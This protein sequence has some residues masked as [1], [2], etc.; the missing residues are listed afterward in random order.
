MSWKDLG[1]PADPRAGVWALRAAGWA[2]VSY[3]FIVL[4]MV[5]SQ[6][7]FGQLRNMAWSEEAVECFL[8]EGMNGG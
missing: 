5:L 8:S 3:L 1:K 6:R 2:P 4:S 7:A